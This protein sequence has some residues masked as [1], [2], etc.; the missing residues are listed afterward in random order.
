MRHRDTLVLPYGV[1]D[2]IVRIALVD[3]PQLLSR[4]VA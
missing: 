1:N 2:A 3:L 4:M